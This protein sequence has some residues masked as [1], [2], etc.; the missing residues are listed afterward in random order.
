LLV[1]AILGVVF[2]SCFRCT[3][4]FLRAIEA[5]NGAAASVGNSGPYIIVP[6]SED[7]GEVIVGIV[8]AKDAPETSCVTAEVKV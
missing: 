4:G 3:G 7:S 5:E 8:A 1:S 2:F 6:T